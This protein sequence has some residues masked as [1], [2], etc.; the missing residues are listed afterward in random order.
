[1][2]HKYVCT[3][4]YKHACMSL[5]MCTAFITCAHKGHKSTFDP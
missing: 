4:V 2:L 1:M 5:C 3:Y